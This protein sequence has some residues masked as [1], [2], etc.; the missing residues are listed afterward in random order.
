MN[1]FAVVGL[2]L[3]LSVGMAGMALAA[4]ATGT[5]EDGFCYNTMGAHGASH[6]ACAIDCAKKGIPVVLLEK[7]GKQI[8]LLPAQ[9]KA[10][11]PSSVVDNMEEKVTVTGDEFHKGGNT[12]LTVKSVK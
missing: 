12:Y 7:G 10:S 2:G 1:K 6:K 11:L 5:L 3:L 4:E 8:V 9:D